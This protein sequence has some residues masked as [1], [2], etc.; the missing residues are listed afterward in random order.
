ME[1]LWLDG[2]KKLECSWASLTVST[3]G[4]FYPSTEIHKVPSIRSFHGICLPLN[5][6]PG[7]TGDVSKER[8]RDIQCKPCRSFC[9]LAEHP[10]LNIINGDHSSNIIQVM[11]G[12]YMK[13]SS[14]DQPA[15]DVSEV[16]T[17]QTSPTKWPAIVD[18]RL[19]SSTWMWKQGTKRNGGH[20]NK[21]PN[22]TPTKDSH[23]QRT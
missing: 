22:K 2:E 12:K 17:L 16:G 15:Y 6:F 13:I 5:I 7:I 23:H 10:Y 1:K 4:G 11:F 3:G 14:F 20:F 9:T 8:I 21:Y 19:A 18:V